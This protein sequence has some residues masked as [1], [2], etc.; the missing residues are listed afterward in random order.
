MP[1]SEEEFL[2][3]LRAA[4]EIEAR[5]HLQVLSTGLLELEKN[6]GLAGKRPPPW[7]ASSAPPTA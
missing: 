1:D 6:P 3:K 5:E 7:S 4:F 2:R